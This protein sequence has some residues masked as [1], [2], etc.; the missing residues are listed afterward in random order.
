MIKNYLAYHFASLI[1]G[2]FV[3]FFCAERRAD[4]LK[5]DEYLYTAWIFIF[6]FLQGD[7]FQIAE[8]SPLKK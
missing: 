2:L 6:Q 3:I 4:L 8:F 7:F 1:Y 5:K